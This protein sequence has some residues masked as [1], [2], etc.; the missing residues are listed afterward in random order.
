MLPAQRW[1]GLAR[2]T[3]TMSHAKRLEGQAKVSTATSPWIA[4]CL[5]CQLLERALLPALQPLNRRQDEG[6]C[7]EGGRC[8]RNSQLLE[9]STGLWHRVLLGPCLMRP[10]RTACRNPWVTDTG[11]GNNRPGYKLPYCRQ[12]CI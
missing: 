4:P 8:P 12:Y 5:Y 2:S 7:W 11:K 3:G 6:S 10:Q 1:S 9:P